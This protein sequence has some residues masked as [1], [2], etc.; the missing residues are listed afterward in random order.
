MAGSPVDSPTTVKDP[1]VSIVIPAYNA[2]EYIAGTLESVFAQV[3]TNYEIIVVNDGSPDSTALRQ[4]LEPYRSRLRYIEQENKGPSGA[5]NAGIRA[6]RGKYIALLDSDDL[7]LPHHLANQ[8]AL[9]ESGQD[10]DLVYSNGLHIIGDRPVGI[11]FEITP[12]TLPV[13]FDTLLRET[14][15]VNTS[16]VLA[17]RE[18]MLSAGLFDETIRRC[19]DYDLWLRMAYAGARM[20]FTRRIEIGHR[21]AN[22]LAGDYD[23]MKQALIHVYEKTAATRKLTDEQMQYVRAKIARIST[24]L[25]FERAKG[26]LLQGDFE[27]ARASLAA[28]Q[29]AAPHAKTNVM[30]LGLRLAPRGLRALHRLHLRY[31]QHK[32]KLERKRSLERAGIGNSF[33]NLAAFAQSSAVSD[34]GPQLVCH[35]AH[36]ETESRTHA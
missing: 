7:W 15:T 2:A 5:R 30:A 24:S 3:F 19:E 1:L 36:E 28:A 17:V 12:Q 27:Q 29:A 20:T 35:T 10:L 9:I 21:L 14:C 11:S 26:F 32:K 23:A 25:H 16:S 18:A 22:G 8:V 6:A 13:N 4:V 34:Q 33:R 31:I